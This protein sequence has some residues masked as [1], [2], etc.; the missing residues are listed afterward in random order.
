M[1]D[2]L[3]RREFWRR[4]NVE[5]Y[6]PTTALAEELAAKSQAKGL[7]V[8][9]IRGRESRG[10][11][12]KPQAAKKAAQLRLNVFQTLCKRRQSGGRELV[13]EFYDDCP[14][15]AQW[16]DTEP[17]IR[18]FAHNYLGLP[19][20]K[21]DG[22][23]LP[24]PDL[25]VVDESAVQKLI[26]T[27]SFSTDRLDDPAL[28][29]VR[30]HLSTGKDLREALRNRGITAD[31]AGQRAADL[32]EKI[33][34]DVTPDMPELE[35]RRLLDEAMQSET[36]DLAQF[37]L[38]VAAEIDLDR[39]FH[40]IEV[41]ANEPV[42]V[43]GVRVDQHRI[44]VYWPRPTV[45]GQNTPL[46]M[47]DADADLEINRIFFGPSLQSVEIKA[48]RNAY[49][50]QCYSTRLSKRTLLGRHPR[51]AP[52][53]TRELR[54]VVAII[55]KE[56]ERG[57]K[58]FVV[59]PRQVRAFLTAADRGEN[60][61]GKQR[62]ERSET[63]H[64]VTIAH[65]HYIRGSNDWSDYDTVIIVGREQPSS[66]DIERTARAI[67]ADDPEP[68]KLIGDHRLLEQQRGYR[69]RDRSLRGVKTPIHPDAR[70]QRVL[71]LVRENEMVQASDR[72]RLIHAK[73]EKRVI[74]L[75]SIPLD[76]TVD[77]LRTLDE[78]AGTPGRLGARGR[79]EL[80]MNTVGLVP[81]GARDLH[82]AYLDHPLNLFPSEGSARDVLKKAR[83]SVRNGVGEN[84]GTNQI[85]YLFGIAPHLR[86]AEYRRAGQRGRPSRVLYDIRRCRN[87]SAELSLLLREPVKKFKDVPAADEGDPSSAHRG[88]E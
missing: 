34:T 61:A 41:C 12:A 84:G 49:F 1:I 56:A 42:K 47:I 73:Q 43:N 65:F 63:W 8:R 40:G 53:M 70:I 85:R 32:I 64:A 71:E 62:L 29:A 60:S 78:L 21:P 23:G 67:W 75:C 50:I 36:H 57:G 46:I 59:M 18:I 25:V 30:D 80:A 39:P 54:K 20:P 10:M 5:Y 68:L 74:I 52:V 22:R 31:W 88:K 14:Y 17:A 86:V 44:H 35:A 6:V 66:R 87:P 16:Q 24:E 37:W 9:V 11:C 51:A 3:A 4:R 13:C 38:R 83:R 2:E 82:R 69:M 15:I 19:R 72:L 33:E 77:E 28:D 7:R 76:I 81:L 79:L 58:V 45:I 55:K 26:G 27:C 48:A